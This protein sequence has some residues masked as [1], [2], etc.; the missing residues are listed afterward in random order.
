M[1]DKLDQLL[2]HLPVV[3]VPTHSN[4]RVGY[5]VFGTAY[6]DPNQF[7]REAFFLTLSLLYL[8]FYLVRY[9]INRGVASRWASVIVPELRSEFSYVPTTTPYGSGPLVWNGAGAATLYA[10]GR[11]N[12]ERLQADITFYP[13]HDALLLLAQLPLSQM[14]QKT[15]EYRSRLD[16]VLTLPPT[17]DNVLGVFGLINK[18]SLRVTRAGRYDLTFAKLLDAE[19]ASTTRGLDNQWAILSETGE[20]TDSWL[21]QPG[22]RGQATRDKLGI[23]QVLNTPQ[24]LHALEA[25]VVTDQPRSKP[26]KGPLVLEDRARQI[27]L[28]LRIPRTAAEA[29]AQLPLLELALNLADA[30]GI[31][32]NSSPAAATGPLRLRPE[33]LTKLRK[34]RREVDAQLEEEASREEREA[35]QEALQEAKAKA[36]AERFKNLSPAEQAKRKEVERKRALRKGQKTFRARG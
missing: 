35:E 16:V 26:T 6:F 4:G 1:A 20:L 13:Y 10:S 19:N 25:L 12:V 31:A 15:E 9:Q 27:I 5:H 21:G 7:H 28:T 11:R 36:E 29:A 8:A 32:T 3:P 33:L 14:G 22:E 17:S 24:A 30:V 23:Q 34:T 2:A 18:T